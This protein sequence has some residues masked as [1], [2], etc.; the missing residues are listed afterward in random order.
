MTTEMHRKVLT[1]ESSLVRQARLEPDLLFASRGWVQLGLKWSKKSPKG[2]SKRC[3]AFAADEEHI[4]IKHVLEVVTARPVPFGKGTCGLADVG[5]V[6]CRHSTKK[7]AC[8]LWSVLPRSE[9]YLRN[10]SETCECLNSIP[11]YAMPLIKH[12]QPFIPHYLHHISGSSSGVRYCSILKC[13]A[14]RLLPCSL[15]VFILESLNLVLGKVY[16]NKV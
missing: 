4:L 10:H 11:T 13:V 3:L 9:V 1:V 14:F 12:F 7:W 6:R 8:V 15:T 16:G 2:V 5:I